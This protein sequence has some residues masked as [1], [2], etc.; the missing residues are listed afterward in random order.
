MA[1]RLIQ[2]LRANVVAYLALAVALGGGG[3]YAIAA[4]RVKTIDGCVVKKTGELLVKSRC[5][6]GQQKLTWNQQ[7]A[8]GAVG[9]TGATGATPFV[10]SGFVALNGA[11]GGTGFT[12]Q[13]TGIG[14]YEITLT[15]P[16][17]GGNAKDNLVVSM[18]GDPSNENGQFQHVQ[19]GPLNNE[20]EFIVSTGNVSG[21][22]Y[23]PADEAFDLIGTC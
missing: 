19:A 3:G 22:S 14:E 18:E 6:R 21:G 23:M 2:H 12:V 10:A 11:G 16:S 20:N 4:T 13:Q 1:V 8:T 7:G 17:C 15:G 5:A 9:A